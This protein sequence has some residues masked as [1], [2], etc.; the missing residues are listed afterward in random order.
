VKTAESV[1]A[2]M[3]AGDRITLSVLLGLLVAGFCFVKGV[4]VL[5]SSKKNG[6]LIALV[7]FIGGIVIGR[8]VALAGCTMAIGRI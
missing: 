6:A 8:G 3:Q 2:A 7:W 1:A 4:G 5:A